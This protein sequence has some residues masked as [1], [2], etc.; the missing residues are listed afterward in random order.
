MEWQLLES[1]QI[2]Q[3]VKDKLR[4]LILQIIV[5]TAMLASHPIP[6]VN[7]NIGQSIPAIHQML[8]LHIQLK[9]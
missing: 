4:H 5:K 9:N 6:A 2:Y 1:P 8:D 3:D 7:V